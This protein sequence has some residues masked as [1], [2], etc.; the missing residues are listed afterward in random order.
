M[1]LRASSPALRIALGTSEALPVPAPT[2]PCPSPTTTTALKLKRRPPFTTLATRLTWTS[3]S[4]NSAMLR[5]ILAIISPQVSGVGCRVSVG[6][7]PR[8]LTP[9][10]W[11]L[12][13]ESSL[14]RAVGESLDAPVVQV[15]AAVEHHTGDARRLRALRDEFADGSRFSYLDCALYSGVEGRGGDEGMAAHVIYKLRVN[16]VQ[17]AKY[18]EARPLSRAAQPCSNPV[19]PLLPRRQ[20]VGFCS[21]YYLWLRAASCGLLVYLELA[22]RNSS[23]SLFLT[24]LTCLTGLAAYALALVCD[25]FALVRL[26]RLELAYLRGLLAHDLL[27]DA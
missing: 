7:S 23:P 24:Y 13:I 11:H 26:G 22:A 3:F 27:V 2:V 10:T 6:A 12:E 9:V 21:H 14:A 1:C 4:S 18:V 19:V 8:H 25:A 16:V 5:S 15:A 17:T 20:H